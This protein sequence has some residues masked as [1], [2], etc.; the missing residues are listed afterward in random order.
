MEHYQLIFKKTMS[1]GQKHEI[2]SKNQ[3]IINFILLNILI[4]IIAD[5][6]FDR[7]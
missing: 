7:F 2:Y 6:N 1:K 4:G 5:R 3:I